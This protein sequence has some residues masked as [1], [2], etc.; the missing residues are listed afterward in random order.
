VTALA[1]AGAELVLL[2]RNEAGVDFRTAHPLRAGLAGVEGQGQ[3]SSWVRGR[4]SPCLGVQGGPG[5]PC[6]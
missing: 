1:E 4:E 2:D 3:P 6:R 5:V